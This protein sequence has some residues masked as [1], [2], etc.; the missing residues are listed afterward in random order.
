MENHDAW[1]ALLAR[2]G[3]EDT[4]ARYCER[5]DEYDIAGVASC[6]AADAE[7]DYGPGRGGVIQGRDAVVARIEAGQAV[8]RRTHH[9][10]GQSRI[11]I[12]AERA[13]ALTY[14]TAWHERFSGEREIVCLR[15][16]DVLRQE[17]GGWRITRRAIEVALVDGFPGVEWNWVRRAPPRT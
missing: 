12:D 15:Y 6:F 8:F 2:Q 10:L 11:D 4:L 3:I 7:A 16:R 14:V 17:A 13:Q 1:P 9:Q 5:L